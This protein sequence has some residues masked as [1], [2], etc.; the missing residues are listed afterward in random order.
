MISWILL[1][2]QA[3]SYLLF[4]V[5]LGA[6]GNLYHPGEREKNVTN[7]IKNSQIKFN[8]II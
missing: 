6:Q 7:Y 1:Q 5:S 2:H 4:Q 3:Q 8:I